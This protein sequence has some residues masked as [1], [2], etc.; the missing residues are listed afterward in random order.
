MNKPLSTAV[1]YFLSPSS[2][3]FF[4]SIPTELTKNQQKLLIQLAK[5][6]VS[7]TGDGRTYQKI[8]KIQERCKI[9]KTLHDDLDVYAQLFQESG[10]IDGGHNHDKTIHEVQ[11]SSVMNTDDDVRQLLRN[12]EDVGGILLQDVLDFYKNVVNTEH[13]LDTEEVK[14]EVGQPVFQKDSPQRSFQ[15][16][17]APPP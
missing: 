2:S 15:P 13:H 14:L 7:R 16:L 9:L 17:S 5:R 1:K 11:S 12:I 6:T 4:T 8:T 10:L 3:R